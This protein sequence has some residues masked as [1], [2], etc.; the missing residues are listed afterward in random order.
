MLS[1]NISPDQLLFCSSPAIIISFLFQSCPTSTLWNVFW[2]IR[3]YQMK[4][5][6][7]INIVFLKILYLIKIF[8][9]SFKFKEIF[10]KAK[11][12]YIKNRRRVLLRLSVNHIMIFKFYDFSGILERTRAN[13][14]LFLGIRKQN[15][16]KKNL[17]SWLFGGFF[18]PCFHHPLNYSLRLLKTIFETANIPRSGASEKQQP[19]AIMRLCCCLPFCRYSSK[20]LFLPQC[21]FCPQ[22]E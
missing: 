5:L 7:F 22:K 9:V 21:T 3:N 6:F 11:G 19:T 14:K 13:P 1:K 18:W 2:E 8:S 20:N 16:R 10:C 12:K 4:E 15:R 17:H